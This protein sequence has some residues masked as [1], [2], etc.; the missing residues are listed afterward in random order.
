MRFG[1]P[2]N[3]SRRSAIISELVTTQH[4]SSI[5]SYI[6]SILMSL[7]SKFIFPWKLSYT[8]C[9]LG[10]PVRCQSTIPAFTW[11]TQA[12]KI[13]LRI[14]W[15]PHC[16]CAFQ[17]NVLFFYHTQYKFTFKVRQNSGKSLPPVMKKEGFFEF[18][19][20]DLNFPLRQQSKQHWSRE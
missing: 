1:H 14:Y 16:C 17:N 3:P 18:L 6:C 12:Q 10:V 9:V 13:S 7:S 8:I 15:I 2:R 11:K 19:G 20:L 5:F 4:S